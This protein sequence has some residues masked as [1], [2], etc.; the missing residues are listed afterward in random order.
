MPKSTN[1]LKAFDLAEAFHL[2]YAVSTLNDLNVLEAL[3]E[4]ATAEKIAAKYRLDAKVLRGVLE[5][6]A[7]RTD[8]VRKTSEQFVITRH[9]R[10]G[11]HFL[12]ELYLGAYGGNSAKL[13]QLLRNPS[14]APSVVDR[15]RYARAFDPVDGS[16]PGFLA[17]L[18][19]RLEL[20]HV[21]DLG[22]GTAE[23]LADLAR[24][25]PKFI[26]WGIEING[27]MCRTARTTI[28]TARLGKQVK[29]LEGDSMN[30]AALL[31]PDVIT[32]VE[33]IT[34]C[35]FANEL[36]RDSHALALE[37]LRGLRKAFRG[38]LLLIDDYYGRLGVK[39]GRQI[40]RET[41]LHDYVQLI[42]GQGIPPA[43]AAEWRSIYS[44]A[45]CR[46]VHIIEDKA[47]TRFIHILK[48]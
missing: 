29:V 22:C 19:R 16:S 15:R 9:Y 45:K 27:E 36:F 1:Q 26:G 24:Q 12:I 40:A 8:L 21:L 4:P 2:S 30:P 38:R 35:N 25:D 11:S 10:S 17:Q 14:T 37:W 23:L 6:L 32:A 13:S 44:K 18:I 33:A 46:L 28:R 47:S 5:Y 39:G 20:N 7:A 31:G 41:L 42:S 48:L 3:K 34:A 43:G